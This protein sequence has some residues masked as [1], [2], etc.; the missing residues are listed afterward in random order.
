MLQALHQESPVRK[1][2]QRVVQCGIAG[3]IG[4]VLQVRPGLSG[5]AQ[6]CGGNLISTEEKTALDEWYIRH[7]SLKLDAVIVLRTIWMLLTHD[8]RDEKAIAVAMLERPDCEPRPGRDEA[9]TTDAPAS[10]AEIPYPPD[11]DRASAGP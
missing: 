3:L 1:S 10:F 5:W 6:V 9:P 4:G 2:G 7:A 11:L 8:R